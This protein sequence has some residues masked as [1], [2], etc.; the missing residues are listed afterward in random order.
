MM[1][2]W[3]VR[4]RGIIK[5]C[6]VVIDCHAYCYYEGGMGP[7]GSVEMLSFFSYIKKVGKC[8]LKKFKPLD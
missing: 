8:M 3:R 1:R 4:K 5:C 2:D 7:S 6:L